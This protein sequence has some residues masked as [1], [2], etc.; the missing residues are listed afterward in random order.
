MRDRKLIFLYRQKGEK[1]DVKRP[2][3]VAIDIDGTLL[4]SD[5]RIMERTK[6]TIRA[7]REEGN[8]V[9]LATGRHP[10]SA[11]PIA[12][13]VGADEALIGLNGSCVLL[14]K[15]T[16][17]LHQQA[18]ETHD[19]QTLVQQL[20]FEHL[21]ACLY[22]WN[23]SI[24][25]N[26]QMAR[27]LKEHVAIDA[28]IL[29]TNRVEQLNE[30]VYMISFHGTYEVLDMIANEVAMLSFPV[31]MVR[32]SEY[33]L[34]LLAPHQSKGQALTKLADHYRVPLQDVMAI[35]NF[36]NDV[37]MFKVAGTGVAVA[38]APER[39][40]RKADLL[41]ASNDEDGVALILERWLAGSLVS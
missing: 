24:V 40:K 2:K 11:L 5:Q 13:E 10:Q 31:T 15:Q 38:N 4:T 19:V 22:L 30:Q 27:L 37:S 41:T 39:V 34:D 32:S 7:F 6:A 14:L 16:K 26:A 18:I 21:G 29:S 17:L 36:D 20:P 23:R 9:V 12:K 8:K 33:S 35:G 1:M 3:L 28:D 25:Y